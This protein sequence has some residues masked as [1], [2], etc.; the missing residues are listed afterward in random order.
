MKKLDEAKWGS[1]FN[2]DNPGG[3]GKNPEVLLKMFIKSQVQQIL[4]RHM[5]P[6]RTICRI[7]EARKAHLKVI[8]AKDLGSR[9]TTSGGL[10]TGA[11]VV[12]GRHGRVVE[13]PVDTPALEFRFPRWED[14]LTKKFD[15][16]TTED[17]QTYG[18]QLSEFHEC[19]FVKLVTLPEN[20]FGFLTRRFWDSKCGQNCVSKRGLDCR[21]VCFRA[22]HS[23]VERDRR[24]AG[25][26][27][28]AF[29]KWYKSLLAPEVIEEFADKEYDRDHGIFSGVDPRTGEKVSDLVHRAKSLD[30]T[31]PEKIKAL[32][33]QQLRIGW[34]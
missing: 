14:C 30:D 16:L 25:H 19:A 21:E 31:A 8:R 3:D 26:H 33:G 10:V 23:K 4:D 29:Q 34:P 6:A 32:I 2:N 18:R 13:H 17:I 7:P 9:A 27:L 12:T 20:R 1:R 22:V 15:A 28:P 5:V 11:S 24:A